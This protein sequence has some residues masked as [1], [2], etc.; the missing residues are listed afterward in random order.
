MQT[1]IPG[2]SAALLLCVKFQVS[3]WYN[4]SVWR[5]SFSSP[6]S[7]SSSEN[8]CLHSWGISSWVWKF[9]LR[10]LSFHNFEDVLL[11]SVLRCPRGELW[12][13]SNH[14]SLIGKVVFISCFWQCFPFPFFFFWLSALWISASVHAFLCIYSV[15]DSLSFLNLQLYMFHQI[16]GIW[17]HYFF[18]DIFCIYLFS[19]SG[20]Q[21]HRYQK[22]SYCFMACVL[23]FIF[24]KTSFISILQV[25]YFSP[26]V[27]GLLVILSIIFP[28]HILSYLWTGTQETSIAR[29][30]L[31]SMPSLC[32]P[33]CV[34]PSEWS[35]RFGWRK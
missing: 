29:P 30:L 22:F 8:V 14:C 31:L 32:I 23:L 33:W 20:V 5:T 27:H 7:F 13:N 34:F 24:K 6:F 15:C 35:W 11:S 2:I 17:G 16:W 9:G 18:K 26:E 28:E 1:Q 19:S 21:W 25:G 10:V 3:L 12:G 4:F